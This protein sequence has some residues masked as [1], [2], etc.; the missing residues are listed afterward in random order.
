MA[1]SETLPE[2]DEIPDLA[3]GAL[4]PAATREQWDDAVLK[5]LNRGRPEGR[6][7]GLDAAMD[8]LR[9]TT[10]DGLQIEPLYVPDGRPL[11]Y[12]GVMPFD[13]GTTLRTGAMEA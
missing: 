6:E 9:T 1:E 7:L 5:V 11:G 8:R 2:Q 13:R 3:L 10:V 4:F 12:P